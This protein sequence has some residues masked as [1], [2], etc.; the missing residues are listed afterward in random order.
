MRKLAIILIALRSACATPA[1]VI[2]FT[3]LDSGPKTGGEGGNGAYVTIYGAFFGS[4]QGSS[5]VSIGGGAPSQYKQWGV[6]WGWAAN[7]YQLITVQLGSAAVTGNITVTT[8]AGTSNGIPFTVRS[9]TIYFASS[10]GGSDSNPGTFASPWQTLTHARDTMAAGDTVY[11][12]TGSYITTDDGQGYSTCML[13]QTG[14]STG[15]PNAMIGY[16]G[17]SATLG[18]TTACDDGIRS[19]GIG[20]ENYWVFANFSTI[21]GITI[22]I[23]PYGAHDWKIIGNPNMTCPNGNNAAGCL[24]IGGGQ[25]GTEYNWFVYGN[26]INHSG[27][28][29]NPTTVTALYHTVY[30]SQNM[31]GVWFGWNIVS[32]SAGGRCIQ[33]NVNDN[34]PTDRLDS[35][36]MHIHDNVIH[37]CQNDGIVMTTVNPSA[38]TVEIYN[39]L[40][41]NA[42][43]GPNNLEGSGAWNCMNLQ[44]WQTAGQSDSG[45]IQVYNNTMYGCGTFPVPPYS[46]NDGGMLWEDG[47]TSTKGMNLHN[48]IIQQTTGPASGFPYFNVY[49]PNTSTCSSA[50]AAVAGSNN[51]FYGNGTNI[52]NT[53]LTA[54][55][56]GSNPLLTSPSTDFSLQSSSPAKYAGVTVSGR[57]MDITG[58]P[59]PQ[60]GNAPSMGA[61]EVPAAG[62]SPVSGGMNGKAKLSGKANIQ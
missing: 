61:Y 33:Q 45:I 53:V 4:S 15:L 19:K 54:S 29:L 58:L 9:G 21:A 35:Y 5:T 2:F 39:N 11:A 55:T 47:N 16:P 22:S 56:T 46:D 24:D 28:N 42:G 1:P 62:G 57:T 12:R 6:S 50:C 30:L 43:T 31:H 14:G 60:G 36:D 44:G 18:S 32:N 17:E 51:L 20:S 59:V 37:D 8:S 38:G 3:D 40:I 49:S 23:G 34:S 48:N 52:T 13:L 26:N 25:D 27:T 10:S 41:F 7:N